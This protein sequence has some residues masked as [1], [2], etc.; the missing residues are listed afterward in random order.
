M[1]T[2]TVKINRA[3]VLTM[4]AAI[5]AERLGHSHA[6]ALSLAKAVTGLNAQSKGRRLGIYEAP[7]R[8]S[9]GESDGKGDDKDKA[10]ENKK[11]RKTPAATQSHQV[12][13][14]LGRQIPITDTQ[15]GPRAVLKDEPVEPNSVERYLHGKFGDHYTDVKEAMLELA[16]AFPPAEL[17]KKAYDLYEAFR[18]T[19]PEGVKGWGAAGT[20]SLSKI[21][22]LAKA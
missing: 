9:D 13:E 4:W 15:D 7:K 2:Q 1:A 21:R 5:V 20:L 17:H 22:G 19:I 18:P 14:L 6:E 3:P 11:E 10:A 16:H 8:E 12:V